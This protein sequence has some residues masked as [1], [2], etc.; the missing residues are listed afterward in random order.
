MIRSRTLLRWLWKTIAVLS[1][2]GIITFGSVL[3]LVYA[4]FGGTA[5]SDRADCAIVFG[6]AVRSL[7]QAG[8]GIVRR[9]E[10][11]ERLYKEYKVRSIFLTGGKGIGNTLSEAQVMRAQA[12]R[13]DV[14]PKDIVLEQKSV[15]TW[16]N[17]VNTRPL[18]KN[19]TTVI[20]I[21][22]QY[23]LAR[24]NLLAHI[25]KWP[26]LHTFPADRRPTSLFEFTSSLREAAAYLYYSLHLTFLKLDG[27]SD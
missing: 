25:Q 16:E 17:L 21:S 12:V 3:G 6:A 24:I 2:T 8:P 23:H 15:S 20:A 27:Y 26:E 11:A 13:H 14:S 9:V 22:D 5:T 7:S 19:C 18:T 4:S 1:L 10:T